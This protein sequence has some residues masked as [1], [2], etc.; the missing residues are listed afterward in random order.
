MT[1]G[2]PGAMELIEPGKVARKSFQRR[3]ELVSWV[4]ID[5]QE[6]VRRIQM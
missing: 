6:F 3:S 2:S 5:D 4:L 1:R